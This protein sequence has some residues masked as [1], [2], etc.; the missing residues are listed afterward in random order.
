MDMLQSPFKKTDE[1]AFFNRILSSLHS[2]NAQYINNL[3]G[4]LSEEDRKYL[5]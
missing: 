4:Q 3:V 5:Q 2:K 1:F